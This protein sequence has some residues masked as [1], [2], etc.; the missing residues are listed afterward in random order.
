MKRARAP[1]L[2]QMSTCFENKLR[3]EMLV[4]IRRANNCN[5]CRPRGIC[6]HSSLYML[7]VRRSLGHAWRTKLRYLRCGKLRNHQYWKILSALASSKLPWLH[8][9][10]LRLLRISCESTVNASTFLRSSCHIPCVGR[11]GVFLYWLYCGYIRA[12]LEV[13]ESFHPRD[14]ERSGL[15]LK[16]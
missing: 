1:L 13:L 8:R 10:L 3:Q 9:P 15:K 5:R 14:K 11:R 7:R 6:F 2:M 4:A 16:C 12:V